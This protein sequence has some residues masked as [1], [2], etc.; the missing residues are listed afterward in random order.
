MRWRL[1]KEP[2]GG[3]LEN[4]VDFIV[5]V[6]NWILEMNKNN[7]TCYNKTVRPFLIAILFSF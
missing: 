6:S 7:R 1:N 3:I 4:S 2:K 5:N